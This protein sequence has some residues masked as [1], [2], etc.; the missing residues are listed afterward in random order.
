M[1]NLNY[2][3]EDMEKEK[4]SIQVRCMAFPSLDEDD[5][6]CAV[7]LEMDI[8][9]FGN[10]MEEAIKDLDELVEIQIEF[11]TGKNKPSLL[12]HPA[13]K[14]WFDLWDLLEKIKKKEENLSSVALKDPSFPHPKKATCYYRKAA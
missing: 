12:D 4:H 14:K 1:T 10:T 11:A 9:G 13:D 5:K 7:A 8:W 2:I 3:E 6:W